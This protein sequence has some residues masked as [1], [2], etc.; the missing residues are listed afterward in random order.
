MTWLGTLAAMAKT[1]TTTVTDDLDGSGNAKAITFGLD[2]VAY[3]IDLST[4]NE[5]KLRDALQEF[6]NYASRDRSTGTSKPSTVRGQRDF[7]IG[8]LRTWAAKK[9]IDLPARGRIPG[10]VIEQYKAAGGR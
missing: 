2:G 1:I 8:A 7:D 3:S 4:R 10:A 5:K 9:R 6:I